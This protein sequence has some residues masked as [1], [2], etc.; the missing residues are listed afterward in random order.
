LAVNT[1]SSE[2]QPNIKKQPRKSVLSVVM[3]TQE[4]IF[5]DKII[6]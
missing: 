6:S 3:C 4:K 1:N 2:V 5:E